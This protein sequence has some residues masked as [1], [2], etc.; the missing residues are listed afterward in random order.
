[1]NR[2]EGHLKE[3][4]YGADWGDFVSFTKA[5]KK[6]AHELDVD[7]LLIDTGVRLVRCLQ[8]FGC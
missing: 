5:M 2:L 3:K 1:M 8:Y 4:N 6:R 7:L